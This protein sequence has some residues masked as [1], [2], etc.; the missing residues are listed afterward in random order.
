MIP[1][2]LIK[3]LQ[4]NYKRQV[5][6][7]IEKVMTQQGREDLEITEVGVQRGQLSELL[8]K[9]FPKIRMNLVDF[10]EPMTIYS[11]KRKRVVAVQSREKVEGIRED[12]L[13]RIE[14]AKDRINVFHMDSGEAAEQIG[15]YS[16]DLIF[17]DG[18]HSREG[19]NRDLE[20]WW[21]KI[22]EKQSI[23]SGHDFKSRIFPVREAV[24]AWARKKDL[25]LQLGIGEVWFV[26]NK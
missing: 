20:A 21:S 16:Q 18:D 5:A 8:L 1:E 22:K 23:F 24:T 13:K 3:T 19:V 6:R 2:L 10:W 12:A 11:E 9:N 25:L 4:I 7:L 14:F 26:I 15:D 17:I